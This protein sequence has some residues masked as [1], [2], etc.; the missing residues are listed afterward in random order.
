MLLL[1]NSIS[2]QLPKTE[3]EIFAFVVLQY[4]QELTHIA[5]YLF[6]TEKDDETHKST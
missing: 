2:G 6:C 4:L 5:K 3:E 1:H